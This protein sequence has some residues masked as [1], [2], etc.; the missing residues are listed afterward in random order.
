M[1]TAPIASRPAAIPACLPTGTSS[2]RASSTCLFINSCACG[3]IASIISFTLRSE[4]G[5]SSLSSS[6][7][8]STRS[9]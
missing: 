1:N 4:G 5:G 9:C 2:V 6:E 8:L 3:E 7:N